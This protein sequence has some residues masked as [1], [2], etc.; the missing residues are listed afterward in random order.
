MDNKKEFNKNFKLCLN[1]IWFSV[2]YANDRN[3]FKNYL[4]IA[5]LKIHLMVIVSSFEDIQDNY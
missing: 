3:D 1:D 4:E 5:E 2:I